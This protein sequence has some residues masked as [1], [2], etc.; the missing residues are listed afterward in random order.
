MKILEIAD[1]MSTAATS[2]TCTSVGLRDL[3]RGLIVIGEGVAWDCVVE[4]LEEAMLFS[5][6]EQFTCFMQALVK[7]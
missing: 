4:S 1:A 6:V 7:S 3:R 2:G 5:S